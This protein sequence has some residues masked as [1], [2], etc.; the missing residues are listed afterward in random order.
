MAH[1]ATDAKLTGGIVTSP[2][3]YRI[4]AILGLAWNAFGLYQFAGAVTATADQL[5]QTGMTAEQ[6]T[7]YAGLPLWMDAVFAIGVVGGFVGSILLFF[8]RRL[9]VPVFL[10]SL[11]G[12]V[13]LY[14][15]D[16]ALGVFAAFGAPQVAILTT[17]VVIAVGLLWLAR[18][19][20]RNGV[21][22]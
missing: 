14:I 3:F 12:Y 2:T 18:T 11:V 16:I 5:R 9:A 15:G 13:A 7:L 1:Q 8:G 10:A 6:A 21:L 17:V 22:R 19:A 20:Q 4:F